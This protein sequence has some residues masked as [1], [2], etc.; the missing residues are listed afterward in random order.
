MPWFAS[1]EQKKI[2]AQ[3]R[4]R[5]DSL[6]EQVNEAQSKLL[7][8]QRKANKQLGLFSSHGIE[9]AKSRFWCAL[10]SSHSSARMYL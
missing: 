6:Q 1:V 5:R 7:N 10:S 4:E 2:I 8:K 3:F 9:E